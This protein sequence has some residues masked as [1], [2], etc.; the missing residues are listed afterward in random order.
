[1]GCEFVNCLGFS[2]G[3]IYHSNGR[4]E[5]YNCYVHECASP[6]LKL[7]GNV[8]FPAE[9]AHIEDCTFT[10]NWNTAGG[11]GALS[12][13]QYTGG[14]TIRGCRFE[15][16]EDRGTGGG[17]I[18]HGFVGNGSVIEDCFF[19]SNRTIGGNGIGGGIR[20]GGSVTVRGCTFWG[21][22]SPTAS[23]GDAVGF[24]SSAPNSRLE[25]NVIAGCTGRGAVHAFN[26][27]LQSSCNVFWQN[28]G[29]QGQYYT[30][31]PTDRIVDPLFCGLESGDFELMAGSPCLPS[32]SIGC[33]LI[34]A[35]GEGNCGVISVDSRSWGE[36]KAA[37]RG[38]EGETR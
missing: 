21:N 27:P 7:S 32:G 31:G 19:L 18:A 14:I 29:G 11:G 38:E 17:A 28:A 5:M 30:P 12:I 6:A 10:D 8:E 15:N 35:F 33:G 36:V 34:G 26:I 23:A 24:M 1:M 22:S 3:A 37:Y 9:S 4:L 13:S 20:A 2:G 25:N 16:N